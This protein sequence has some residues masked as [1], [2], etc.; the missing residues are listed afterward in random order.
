MGLSLVLVL[1]CVGLEKF[2]FIK[3]RKELGTN[4]LVS[5]AAACVTGQT[6]ANAVVIDAA[7]RPQFPFKKNPEFLEPPPARTPQSARMQPLLRAPL[8]LL[9]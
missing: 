2:V 5:P 9:T 4:N 8:R 1:C 7:S 3:T 6:E